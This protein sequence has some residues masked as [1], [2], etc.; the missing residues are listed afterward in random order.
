MKT[1]QSQVKDVSY[2]K[3]TAMGKK[4]EIE[5][6]SSSFYLIYLKKG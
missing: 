6:F 3:V 4:K 2:M 5:H 1:T